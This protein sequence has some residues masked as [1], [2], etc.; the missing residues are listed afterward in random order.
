MTTTT[1]IESIAGELL[2]AFELSQ[3]TWKLALGA[4]T[5]TAPRLVSVPAGDL[6]RVMAELGKAKRRFGLAATS[7]VWSV[8]E[9]GRDGFWIHRWLT[10]VGV[11]NLVLEASSI[12]VP[13]RARRTKTDRLD[14]GKLLAL[15]RRY[16]AGERGACAVVRVPSEADEDRRQLHRGLEAARADRTRAINRIHGLLATQGA[17][18]AV[19]GRFG[20]QIGTLRR[21]DGATLPPALQQRLAREWAQVDAIDA[22]IATLEAARTAAMAAAEDGA[23][24]QTAQLRQLAGVD[25]S[26]WT[27]VTE[28]FA[29]REFQH[30][31]QI[32]AVT[33]LAPTLAA[34]GAARRPGGISQAGRREVRSLAVQIAWQWLRWQPASALSRWY[35]ARWGAAGARGKK[36]GIVA[37]ARKLLIAFWRFVT[38]GA[39]PE[40][41][42]LK[43]VTA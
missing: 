25:T 26:A 8:Y 11:T 42:V 12:E 20:R 30:G 34:S 18:V 33:G 10:Q 5:G 37:L 39:V 29:W 21:W 36:I 2:V 17:S 27:F 40:G 15:L 38:T 28:L 4:T 32:A 6:T 31:R 3:R 9:I 7:R 1:H 24:R 16:R 23:A 22:Q 13:R 35:Q 41:A 19:T 43:A 14:A